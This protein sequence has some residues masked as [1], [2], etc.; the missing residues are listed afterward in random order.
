MNVDVCKTAAM[1][2]AAALV[3][4][5][6]EGQEGHGLIRLS[7]YIAQ[8]Q[9]GKINRHA[10]IRVSHRGP[11]S[12]LIDADRG[13]AYPAL[14]VALKKGLPV[15]QETGIAI[16]AVGN[17]HHCGALSVHVERVARDGLIG[18][19]FA[20]TPKSVGPWGGR[21][22]I[23]GTNPIAFAAP[24]RRDTPLVIDLS[25]SRVARGKVMAAKKAGRSIPPGWALDSDG[26]PTTDP[27]AALSGTMIPMGAAKGTALALMV[28]VLSAVFSASSLSVDAGSFFDAEG[29]SPRVGQTLIAIQPDHSSGYVSR[30]EALLGR[31]LEIDGARLPGARREHAVNVSRDKGLSLPRSLWLRVQKLAT[32]HSSL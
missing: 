15:A 10:N 23:F 16:M 17:S 2:V 14:D 30:I 32:N 5:E 21:E 26:N 19:M 4:A 7:D 24:R 11:A 22:P 20:N 13:F 9:S 3:A 12:L 31:I 18:L 27:D 8:V 28:E 29:L 1:S 25:L 6:A